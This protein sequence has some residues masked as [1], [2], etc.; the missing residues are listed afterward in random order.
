VELRLRERLRELD[1]RHARAAADVGGA[2]ARA[3]ALD[4][5]AGDLRQSERH[6]H[7]LEPGRERLLDAL[8]A[9]GTERVVGQA[10]SALEGLGQAVDDR[11][12]LREVHE[13]AGA[14]RG[15]VLVGEHRLGSASA[16]RPPAALEHACEPC[17]QPL[18]SQRSD[19]PAW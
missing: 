11:D 9:F 8:R 10:D 13:E 1:H 6:E 14:V 2:S 18:R 3:Q 7:G 4:H 16:K 5:A 17:Q 15:V 12:R 19:R